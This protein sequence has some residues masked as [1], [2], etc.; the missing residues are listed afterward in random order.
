MTFYRWQAVENEALNPRVLRRV[1]HTAAMTVAHMTLLKGAV[2]PEHSHVQEQ[3]CTVERGAL[4][5]TVSGREQVVRAGETLAL[6]SME[7][8]SAEALED[9]HVLDVFSPPRADW[10]A[11]DDAYLRR[12]RSQ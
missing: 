10:I 11:G 6:A 2:V 5:F 1:I 4:K 12:Q 9:S 7:P 8:H 3:I